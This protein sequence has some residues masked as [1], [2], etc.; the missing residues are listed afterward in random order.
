MVKAHR[1]TTREAHFLR[2]LSSLI[3]LPPGEN[4]DRVASWLE[5]RSYLNTGQELEKNTTHVD[6]AKNPPFTGSKS[7]SKNWALS[8]D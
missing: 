8:R 7:C 6:S 2:M 1:T 3:S 4:A 5:A